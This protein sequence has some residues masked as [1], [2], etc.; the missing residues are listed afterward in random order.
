M[1]YYLRANASYERLEQEFKKYGRL[2]FAVDFD[3]TLY[4]YHKAGRS[5]DDL[6]ALLR[7]WEP[8]SEV[9]IFTGNAPE[10]EAWIRDYLNAAGVK[11]LGI[12]CDG[13]VAYPGRKVYANVYIDDRGGLRQIYGELLTLI[14]KIERGEVTYEN[15]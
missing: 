5:Y 15:N 9:I 8:Y 2:I 1:D 12:N 14:E 10:K 4:D 6:M 7:R 11:Y 3:D 13:S